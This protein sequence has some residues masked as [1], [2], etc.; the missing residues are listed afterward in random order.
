MLKN[1]VCHLTKDHLPF[2]VR[3]FHRECKSLVKAGY[4]VTLITQ[5]NKDEIVDGVKIISLPNQMNGFHRIL[6]T[7]IHVLLVALKQKAD[8]YHFHDPELLP[9][10]VFLK[11]FT[12]AK[13]FYD[14]HEDYGKL[15]LS[16]KNFPNI[17]K[18]ARKGISFFFNMTEY[19]SSM[20]FDG[21][22]SATDDIL[23]KFSHH[24]RKISIRNFPIESRFAN[25]KKNNDNSMN[26]FN[27]IYIGSISEI[28]GITQIVKAL[29]LID[30]DKHVKLTLCGEF[31]PA[32]YEIELRGLKGF[33]K[34]EYLGLVEHYAISE[35]LRRSDAGI[36][37]FFPEPNHVNAMPN[38]LFEYSAVGLPVIASNFPLWKQIVEGNK[39][40]VCV[41][42]LNL[43][44]IAMAIK[45][46]VEDPE[47]RIEMGGN[48]RRAFFKEFNWEREKKKLVKIY[49]E[50][51]L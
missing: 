34:V 2:D 14:V 6:G 1:K 3:I 16:I 37:C 25:I 24:R 42:P 32:D 48:G 17:P 43:E 30:S 22:I 28:R 44:E 36:V 21:I 18:I 45:F 41:D 13:V 49:K 20:V 7:I 51:L 11:L 10:G 5:H 15:V 12:S 4:D 23:G 38:K 40:G 46:L 26:V 47:L 9:V 29:E 33:E 35:L 8:L 19:L 31:S 50:V 27:L 39:C